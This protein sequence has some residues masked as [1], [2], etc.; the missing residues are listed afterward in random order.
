MK[1]FPSRRMRGDGGSKVP[2][3]YLPNLVAVFTYRKAR[4]K[5]RD[6]KYCKIITNLRQLTFLYLS[7]FL[8]GP[9][10]LYPEPLASPVVLCN[11]HFEVMA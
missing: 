8:R 2:S 4:P 6:V 5:D 3:C 10:V 9:T 7:I 11:P 1:T